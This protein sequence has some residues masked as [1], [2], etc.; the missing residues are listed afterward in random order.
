MAGYL[1]FADGFD[2]YNQGSGTSLN[3]AAYRWD[4]TSPQIS[5]G[6]G[7]YTTETG[8]GNCGFAT[9]V[10]NVTGAATRILGM[11][12]RTPTTLQATPIM[13]LLDNGV[14]QVEVR[15]SAT[16]Q[17]ELWSGNPLVLKS[18]S[19]GNT[20]IPNN[21]YYM[22]L[23]A[24]FGATGSTVVIVNADGWTFMN[25]QNNMPS[26]R[27]LANQIRFS[28]SNIMLVDDLYTRAADDPAAPFYYNEVSIVSDM[29]NADATDTGAS[30]WTPNTGSV[31]YDR[32]KEQDFDGDTTY[33]YASAAGLYDFYKFPARALSGSNTIAAIITTFYGRKDDVSSRSISHMFRK[34]DLTGVASDAAKAMTQ[35][36]AAYQK[37][38]EKRPDGVNWSASDISSPG[39]QFG[40][41]SGN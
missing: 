11:A 35:T 10:K 40:V 18:N 6:T 29:P 7:R 14:A 4:V 13:A 8:R 28:V 5:T 23:F 3:E 22:E 36:Y 37:V 17:V 33:V 25:S 12:V 30:Q 21:W 16:G 1:E 27:A 41:Q 2:S 9:G 20:V 24:S 32:V 34:A 26:G 38:Y 19:G 31:H 39:A 15:L